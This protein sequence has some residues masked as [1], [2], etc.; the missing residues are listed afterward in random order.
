[1]GILF[2]VFN[3]VCLLLISIDFILYYFCW[4]QG[5]SPGIKAPRNKSKLGF[6]IVTYSWRHMSVLDITN[7]L[8]ISMNVQ[9]IT[10]LRQGVASNW[11]RWNW[12]WYFVDMHLMHPCHRYFWFFYILGIW[13]VLCVWTSEQ[14][15]IIRSIFEISVGGNSLGLLAV[16]NCG[17][18]N[19]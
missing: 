14:T 5:F 13:S 3:S 8:E 11:L 17:L 12:A 4:L 16:K 19:S 6:V 2:V 18:W 7:H 10:T 15:P 1:M 9:G